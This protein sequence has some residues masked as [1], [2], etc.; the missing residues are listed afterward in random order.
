MIIFAL[1]IRPLRAA[2]VPMGL[3]AGAVIVVIIILLL[4]MDIFFYW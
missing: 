4:F 2:D 1:Y 3:I